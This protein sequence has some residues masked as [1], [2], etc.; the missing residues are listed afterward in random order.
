MEKWTARSLQNLHEKSVQLKSQVDR[1]IEIEVDENRFLRMLGNLA[2]NSIEAMPTGGT[3]TLDVEQRNEEVAIRIIDTGVGIPPELLPQIFE[4]F[5]TYGKTNGTGL[6]MAVVKSV[7]EAHGGKIS[8][9][10]KVG[11]GTTVEIRIP[12]AL[13]QVG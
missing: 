8:I 11:R 2:K 10:S 5:V 7:V 6:G 12:S 9:T 3:L 13:C 1:A 4:P